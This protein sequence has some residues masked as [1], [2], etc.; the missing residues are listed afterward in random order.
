MAGAKPVLYK[1]SRRHYFSVVNFGR[2]FPSH[3]PPRPA[4]TSPRRP[5]PHG[6]RAYSAY[7]LRASGCH[8]NRW[9]FTRLGAYQQLGH[10]ES[11]HPR[12]TLVTTA[13]IR[14]HRTSRHSPLHA[15]KH[16]RHKKRG[17]RSIPSIILRIMLDY[18][19]TVTVARRLNETGDS[20]ST[21][22]LPLVVMLSRFTP[23]LTSSSATVAA[24]FSESCWL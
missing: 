11:H 15:P 20:S 18:S 6:C 9:T 2:H 1:S 3:S 16:N 12:N 17:C 22:P 19:T 24:R 4:G 7:R 8:A 14:R 23:I 10:A 5:A 21:P 13:N